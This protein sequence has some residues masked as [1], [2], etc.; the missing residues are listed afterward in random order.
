MSVEDARSF[1]YSSEEIV[2]GLLLRPTWMNSWTMQ[3]FALNV[4]K[5]LIWPVFVIDAIQMH[6]K[7]W[8]AD[9]FVV[10]QRETMTQIQK[11]KNKR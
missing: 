7:T 10:S 5:F 6:V 11:E 9:V 8:Y 4:A 3:I 2:V 1:A